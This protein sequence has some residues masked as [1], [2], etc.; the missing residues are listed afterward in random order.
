MTNQN[1]C[2]SQRASCQRGPDQNQNE[3][4]NNNK[5]RFVIK[6]LVTMATIMIQ[7][8]ITIAIRRN[9]C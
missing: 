5:N 4:I 1:V 7:K 8:K 2:V 9:L 3:S 6:C